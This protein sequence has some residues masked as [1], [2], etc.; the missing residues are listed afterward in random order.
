MNAQIKLNEMWKSVHIENYPIKT[1]SLICQP[2]IINT[3][4]RFSG[5]LKE[6]KFTN[7][8]ERTFINDAIHIWN[9]APREIKDSP[10]IHI[11]KK[12][13]KAFVA[14]LPI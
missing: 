7:K 10:S 13:I 2:D 9:Q 11:A 1:D 5:L 4:A 3:R 14:S 12:D 8:S 6:L